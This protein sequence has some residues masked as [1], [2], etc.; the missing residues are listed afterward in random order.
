M[1]RFGSRE[2]AAA[3][4]R[5]G[6][7]PSAKLQ[8]LKSKARDEAQALLVTQQLPSLRFLMQVRDDPE[9]PM[10]E[11]VRCA[12]EL[13]DRGTTPAVSASVQGIGTL[14]DME[15]RF[16]VP[17][18]VVTEKYGSANGDA[19]MAAPEEPDDRGDS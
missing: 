7:R 11:R 14:D 5:L 17:K 12:V 8:S 9:V 16:G 13:L 3:A 18:L 2:Q 10:R 4:G 1:G 19:P 6:G 15:Q